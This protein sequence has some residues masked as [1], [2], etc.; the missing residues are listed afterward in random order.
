M[1]VVWFSYYIYI[2]LPAS[3]CFPNFCIQCILQ[4]FLRIQVFCISVI[5][6]YCFPRQSNLLLVCSLDGLIGVLGICWSRLLQEHHPIFSWEHTWNWYL[7]FWKMKTF[8]LCSYSLNS[9][10]R[11]VCS[12]GYGTLPRKASSFFCLLTASGPL[13]FIIHPFVYS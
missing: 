10:T 13:P 1:P 12:S 11:E 2:Y 6:N 7:P 8:G 3:K 4:K 5:E 9:L